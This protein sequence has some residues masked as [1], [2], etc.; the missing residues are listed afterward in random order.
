MINIYKEE[1]KKPNDS[2]NVTLRC[3]RCKSCYVGQNRNGELVCFDCGCVVG[4]S[5][6]NEIMDNSIFRKN[7]YKRV[8]YLNERC[9]RWNCTEPSIDNYIW[10]FIKAESSKEHVYGKI[11]NFRRSTVSKILK[12]V[13]LPAEV[14]KQNKSKKFKMNNFTK[15]RFYDKHY[16]KWKTI[17]ERLGKKVYIPS[18]QLIEFIK[19]LFRSTLIPFEIYRHSR[20][21]NKI[22][23]CS[24]YYGC[25]RNFINYDYMFRKL[26]QIA[27]TKGFPGC[28]EKFKDDFNLVSKRIRE[29]KLRPIFFK[30]CEHN[31]WPKIEKDD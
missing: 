6:E 23:D 10:L 1:K 24:K 9:T 16:E 19:L 22:P 11:E 3:K 26:L 31:N 21:C 4:P 28:F 7:T 12:S 18:P 13:K 14:I 8:F 25:Q 2:L 20:D 17:L 27:E 29:N 15:K 5:L 30:I